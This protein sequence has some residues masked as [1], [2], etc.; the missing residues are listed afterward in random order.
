MT[1]TSRSIVYIFSRLLGRRF[2]VL[3]TVLV[4]GI[5]R[6]LFQFLYSEQLR[7]WQADGVIT[8]LHVAMS[9][10]GPKVWPVVLIV[11]LVMTNCV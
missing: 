3:L 9:R 2:P 11:G 5:P 7:Q 1:K 8:A 4:C 10:E 6:C